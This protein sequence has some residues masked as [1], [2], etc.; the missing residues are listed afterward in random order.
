MHFATQHLVMEL[1]DGVDLETLRQAGPLSYPV[2]IHIIGEIL[3]GSV[4]RITCRCPVS[5]PRPTRSPRA[6]RSE[7]SSIATCP[8]AT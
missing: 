4:T 3:E 1:V 6:A 8:T 7:A 5:S 2:I